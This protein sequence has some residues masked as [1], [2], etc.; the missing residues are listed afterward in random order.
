MEYKEITKEEAHKMSTKSR[1]AIKSVNIG[2][3][4]ISLERDKQKITRDI[5]SLV[6]Y[7]FSVTEAV[8]KN[9]K[10]KEYFEPNDLLLG[11]YKE[12]KKWLKSLGYRVELFPAAWVPCSEH[13]LTIEW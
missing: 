5:Y 13:Y 1:E 9:D 11:N 6:G 4:T 7:G 2:G 3:G 10:C 12:I 8:F